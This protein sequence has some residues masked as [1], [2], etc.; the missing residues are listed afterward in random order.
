M[1]VN[2]APDL[3][4]GTLDLLIL[5]TLMRG[6]MHGYAI[7]EHLRSDDMLL[8]SS[9]FPHW[10]FDGDERLP[11]GIPQGLQRKILVENPLA[12]YDRLN[13]APAQ[14]SAQ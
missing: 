6:P 5:K 4:P 8:F 2:Q 10:Q 12:T 13:Q 3:L 14:E 9:D 11:K 1:A 7:V